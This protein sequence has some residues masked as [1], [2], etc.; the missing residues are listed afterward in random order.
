MKIWFCWEK[1]STGRWSPVC[2]HGD[3]PVNE[4][5]SDGDRP[6]RSPLYEV[7]TECLDV[8]GNP[9]FGKLALLFPAPGEAE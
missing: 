3:Q 9:Q 2:Y 1:S 7:S 6:M 8:D 4:K 5:V